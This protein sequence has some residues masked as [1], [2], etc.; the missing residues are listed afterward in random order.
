MTAP[1]IER[2]LWEL[3]SSQCMTQAERFAYKTLLGVSRDTV[4]NFQIWPAT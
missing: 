3:H 2:G 4:S 1:G